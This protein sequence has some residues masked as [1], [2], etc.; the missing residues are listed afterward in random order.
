MDHVGMLGGRID[1]DNKL[2][3]FI[4][5]AHNESNDLPF[6][7]RPDLSPYIVHLTKNTN[8]ADE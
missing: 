1:P 3:P 2:E 5:M 7:E 4:H 8:K 6:I